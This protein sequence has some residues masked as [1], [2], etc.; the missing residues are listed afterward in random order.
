MTE[1]ALLEAGFD[2]PVLAGQST[3]RALM[4]ALANP[5]MVQTLA[6]VR[7]TPPLA[8]GLAGVL[9]TLA[10]HDTPVW[11]CPPL[12]RND[13]VREWMAFHT[14]APLTETTA[15]AQ[16]AVVA[17]A[18]ELPRLDR[19]A[20]GTDEYPDR[21]TTIILGVPDFAAGQALAL[22]GPGIADIVRIAPH[23][24]P[25]DFIEQWTQNRAAFPRGVD[26]LLVCGDQVIGLPRTTKIA[27]VA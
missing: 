18:S 9:L 19:F 21:S 20:L 27:G 26:L 10:D 13:A 1:A 11:L 4:D 24:L 15:T 8:T 7:G 17:E 16:F 5:G 3:F 6:P 14:A 22:R 12:A 2:N 25:G 23:G